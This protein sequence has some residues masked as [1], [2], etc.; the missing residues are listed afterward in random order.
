MS[1]FG[2]FLIRIQS[3]CWKIRTRTTT[4]TDNLHA[5]RVFV[6]IIVTD[7]FYFTTYLPRTHYIS[8]P[9]YNKPFM[10]WIRLARVI[11]NRTV[12]YN[13]WVASCSPRDPEFSLQQVI[14][15]K[16]SS[17]HLCLM[18]L[19]FDN[20]CYIYAKSKKQLNFSRQDAIVEKD[21]N[22]KKVPRRHLGYMWLKECRFT[23]RELSCLWHEQ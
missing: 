2:V 11:N 3:E 7:Y 10:G 16:Y 21:R 9:T 5:V 14:N 15:H 1:V 22:Y 4:N 6:I 17:K 12:A 23:E 19:S 18:Y 20:L 13:S 8:C